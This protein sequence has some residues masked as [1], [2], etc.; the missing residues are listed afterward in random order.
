M[1]TTETPAT[2]RRRRTTEGSGDDEESPTKRLQRISVA[3]SSPTKPRRRRSRRETPT[4]SRSVLTPSSPHL[5]NFCPLLSR[6]ILEELQTTQVPGH[7]FLSLSKPETVPAVDFLRL[8]RAS[9]EVLQLLL[10]DPIVFK[11]ADKYGAACFPAYTPKSQSLL[12]ITTV[13]PVNKHDL[14]RISTKFNCAIL[15]QVAIIGT[16]SSDG[17]DNEDSSDSDDPEAV[18]DPLSPGASIGQ[19]GGRRAGSLGGLLEDREGVVYGETC[20]HVLKEVGMNA[21]HPGGKDTDDQREALEAQVEDERKEA[22]EALEMLEQARVAGVRTAKYAKAV[23]LS[24]ASVDAMEADI[25]LLAQPRDVG[26]VTVRYLGTSD[27]EDAAALSLE[28]LNKE[29]GLNRMKRDHSGLHADSLAELK[30]IKIGRVALSIDTALFRIHDDVNTRPTIKLRPENIFAAFTGIAEPEGDM[31][32]QKLGKTTK[33]TT[34]TIAGRRYVMMPRSGQI[35]FEFIATSSASAD[36]FSAKGDS[37]G[38]VWCSKT[39]KVVAKIMGEF[40]GEILLKCSV[41]SSMPVCLA[42]LNEEFDGAGPLSLYQGCVSKR[43]IRKQA[44]WNHNERILA[45]ALVSPSSYTQLE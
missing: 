23:E 21:G 44:T 14:D 41:L 39:K 37:G 19:L 3:D 13:A 22:A 25:D 5:A 34:G 8:L 17:S 30:D 7:M 43:H 45:S 9:G 38:W 42:K 31:A 33:H 2:P 18:L 24:Q 28:H 6:C 15:L 10:S 20:A 12:V 11:I 40:R 26:L 29:A 35:T 36:G 27:V 4:R 32:V 16:S 1:S